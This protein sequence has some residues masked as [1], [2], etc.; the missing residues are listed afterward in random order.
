MPEC[1]KPSY[2][3]GLCAEH[4]NKYQWKRVEE[5]QAK[6]KE[7]GHLVVAAIVGGGLYLAT[8]NEA[9][10][11][12]CAALWGLVAYNINR[13]T[14]TPKGWLTIAAIPMTLAILYGTAQSPISISSEAEKPVY[15]CGRVIS[16]L[17][18]NPT[19][20]WTNADERAVALGLQGPRDQLAE[21]LCPSTMNGYRSLAGITLAVAAVPTA[22]TIAVYGKR[23]RTELQ[24][25]KAT[26]A[27]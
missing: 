22:V 21:G 18:R 11:V 13:R 3:L 6:W 27:W 4:W 7:Y 20:A 15:Q 17:F 9:A 23:K 12:A 2:Q 24:R 5:R 26:R 8:K 1:D 25:S 14:L 19:S 10:A 16:H